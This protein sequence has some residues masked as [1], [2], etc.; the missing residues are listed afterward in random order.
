VEHCCETI[1]ANVLVP[2][3]RI[4]RSSGARSLI[5]LY[6]YLWLHVV[7]VH[8]SSINLGKGQKSAAEHGQSF[9]RLLTP[10]TKPT[11]ATGG[12]HGTTAARSKQT[13]KLDAVR[14]AC[15]S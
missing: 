10:E 13:Y 1:D 8:I 15:Y 4:H 6:Y 9:S 7:G 5:K 11:R 3:G 12:H 2:A 14:R